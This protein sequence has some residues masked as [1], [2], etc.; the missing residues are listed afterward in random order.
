MSFYVVNTPG[1]S[2]HIKKFLYIFACSSFDQAKEQRK[3]F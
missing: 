1:Y 2:V 3:Q